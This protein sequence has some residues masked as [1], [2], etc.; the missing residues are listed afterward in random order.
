MLVLVQQQGVHVLLHVQGLAQ[1]ARISNTLSPSFIAGQA[2]NESCVPKAGAG[3][4]G[5]GTDRR[6]LSL[7]CSQLFRGRRPLDRERH[8]LVASQEQQAQDTPLFP[9][10]GD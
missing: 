9:L 6:D 3:E 8:N 10:Q 7:L 4:D 1:P 5:L 2:K